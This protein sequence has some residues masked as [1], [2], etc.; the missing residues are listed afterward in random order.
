MKHTFQ[1][2][3]LAVLIITFFASIG[4]AQESKPTEVQIQDEIQLEKS[5][6]KKLGFHAGVGIDFL[7]PVIANEDDFILLPK[8]DIVVGHQFNPYFGVDLKISNILLVIWTAELAPKFNFTNSKISPFITASI[9]G[10]AAIAFNDAIGA[11]LYTA[12]GGVDFNI[13]E[14]TQITAMVR[15]WRAL[16]T[17]DED[18]IIMPELSVQFLF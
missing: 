9:M 7:I 10:G 13:T 2:A 1:Q 18:T 6:Y 15:A 16:S 17:D 11:A 3:L 5:S 14:K 4:F 12:G 8:L